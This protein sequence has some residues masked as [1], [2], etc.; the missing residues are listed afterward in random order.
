MLLGVAEG[1]G[2]LAGELPLECNMDGLAAVSFTKGCYLGQE[3][4]SRTH[5]RGVIRKRV[6][7]FTLPEGGPGAAVGDALGK[8]GRVLA[9]DGGKEGSGGGVGV[10]LVRLETLGEDGTA[11]LPVGE[12]GGVMAH[13]RKPDWWPDQWMA[14]IKQ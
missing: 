14:S 13:V 12:A 2:E 6:L 5:F 3:L 10:A 4:T 7:P 11:L 1:A 8:G 9:F